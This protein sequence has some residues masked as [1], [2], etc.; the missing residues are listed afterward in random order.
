MKFGLMLPRSQVWLERLGIFCDAL[1]HL[2]WFASCPLFQIWTCWRDFR[3]EA[4]LMIFCLF[5]IF[6]YLPI[7]YL[8]AVCSPPAIYMSIVFYP[9]HEMLMKHFSYFTSFNFIFCRPKSIAVAPQS[10]F[11]RE[12]ATRIIWP[13]TRPYKVGPCLLVINGVI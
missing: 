2:I 3:M 9:P 7:M 11:T 8:I 13:E 6:W 5:T 10:M 12:D 4:F 1:V